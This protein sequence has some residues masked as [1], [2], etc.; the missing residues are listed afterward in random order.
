MTSC[1]VS[2]ETRQ[3]AWSPLPR[4]LAQVAVSHFLSHTA[5]LESPLMLLFLLIVKRRG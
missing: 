5:C 1:L 3:S 2:R 4:L